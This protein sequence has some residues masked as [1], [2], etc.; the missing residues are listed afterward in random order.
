MRLFAQP[1]GGA[2][3]ADA[4]ARLFD[5]RVGQPDDDHDRIAP[6]GV[7]LDLDRISLDAIDGRKTPGQHERIVWSSP[8]VTAMPNP[9][10]A[11]AGE[12]NRF[13]RQS[14]SWPFRALTNRRPWVLG[15]AGRVGI[16]DGIE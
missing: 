3:G 6:A 15:A 8:L 2:F 7:D 5:R 14:T 13:V 16:A 1:G 9:P 11:P 10:A 12:E 4:V